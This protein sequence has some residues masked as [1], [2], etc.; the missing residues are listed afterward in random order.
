MQR[1]RIMHQFGLRVMSFAMA[2][3]ILFIGTA[4][5]STAFA[6]DYDYDFYDVSVEGGMGVFNASNETYL[7][8]EDAEDPELDEDEFRSFYVSVKNNNP[9]DRRGA[10]VCYR[11]DGGIEHSFSDV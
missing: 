1:N 9:A 4:G 3:F 2:C 5:F 8:E 10:P 7:R 11:V 6:E